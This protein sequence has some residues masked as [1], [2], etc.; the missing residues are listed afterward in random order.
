M[1]QCLKALVLIDDQAPFS[2]GLLQRYITL[3][4][5]DLIPSSDMYVMPIQVC[6]CVCIYIHIYIYI[7]THTGKT[8]MHK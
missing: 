6:V 5:G 2:H 7:H 3:I 4:L 8:F 1:A